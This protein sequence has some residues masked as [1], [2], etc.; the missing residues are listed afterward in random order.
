MNTIRETFSDIADIYD[1][2]NRALSLGLDRRWRRAAAKA[3]ANASRRA[4]DRILDLACGTG[5]MSLELARAFP[6]ASV[7]G[8][9]FTPAMLDIARRK[10]AGES[11][12]SFLEGD[13]S[14]LPFGNPGAAP[15]GAPF[16]A[17]FCAW[18]FRNFPDRAK[19]LRE[20]ARVLAPGGTLVVLE[21]FRPER[22]LA[23]ALTSLWLRTLPRLLAPSKRSAY[24]YLDSSMRNMVSVDGFSA[25][26]A[27]A[28]FS[29]AS[30]RF[31]FPACTC[32]AFT[33]ESRADNRRDA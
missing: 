33:L 17:V 21:F 13:A 26:A 28:G 7:T 5:D 31:L 8:V 22:R 11:R 15:G 32:L 10:C 18:G 4:P 27:E 14:C 30:S 23:G 3:A 29:P 6:E 2:M 16:D 20:C 1:R 19:A 24:A 9:D 25:L 12:I